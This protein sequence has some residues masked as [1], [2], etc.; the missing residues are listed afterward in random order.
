MKSHNKGYR[1]FWLILITIV[2]LSSLF[3]YFS[4]KDEHSPTAEQHQIQDHKSQASKQTSEKD[5]KQS[6]V[7]ELPKEKWHLEFNPVDNATIYKRIG[8]PRSTNKALCISGTRFLHFIDQ[9]VVDYFQKNIIEPNHPDIFIYGSYHVEPGMDFQRLLDLYG[10]YIVGFYLFPWLP[11]HYTLTD[12]QKQL[13]APG[14]K[15]NDVPNMHGIY[16]CYNILLHPYST[17][18]RIKPYDGMSFHTKWI[19]SDCNFSGYAS[20]TRCTILHPA[21]SK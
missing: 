6:G 7:L 4:L 5:S 9:K 8:A 19:H 14:F 13:F 3:F 2:S 17:M 10:D 15:F 18:Y 21:R 11:S 12:Y 20:S 1:R 16:N